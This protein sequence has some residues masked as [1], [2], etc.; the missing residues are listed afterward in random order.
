MP[1]PA[2]GPTEED[3]RALDVA[4]AREISLELEALKN[5]NQ[6]QPPSQADQ[7]SQPDP[8]PDFDRG[9]PITAPA[10]PFNDYH[11]TSMTAGVRDASPAASSTGR[12]QAPHPYAELNPPGTYSP[13]AAPRSYDQ[14]P[15]QPPPISPAQAYAQSYQQQAPDMRSN[16]PPRFLALNNMAMDPQVPP[17][18]QSSSTSIP[19][20]FQTSYST[21]ASAPGSVNTPDQQQ[22]G[23]VI[24]P[25]AYSRPL[26][27]TSPL[28]KSNT[29]PSSI[30]NPPVGSTLPL[31]INT[32]ARTI[33]AAAFKRPVQRNPGST[34]SDIMI[35]KRALPGSPYPLRDTTATSSPGSPLSVQASG[36]GQQQHEMEDDYD[37]IGAYVDNSAPPSP[38]RLESPWTSG[39]GQQGRM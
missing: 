15:Y 39:Q 30:R 19:P 34:D 26:T 36:T 10:P 35:G 2:I 9:R 8:T 18:F 14:Q 24:P 23:D 20:R 22:R 3:E 31:N 11:A 7:S 38:Q 13:Y 33:N 29:P 1:P 4:A 16:L 17:R 37:Y 6:N 28:I 32:G 12:S 27:S 25:T 5:N 21:P